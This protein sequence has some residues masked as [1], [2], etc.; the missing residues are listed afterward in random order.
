[1]ERP[2]KKHKDNHQIVLITSDEES[3]YINRDLLMKSSPVLKK[4][5]N[6]QSKNEIQCP[7][8][9][10]QMQKVISIWTKIEEECG[11]CLKDCGAGILPILDYYG[12][13]RAI[14]WRKN[15]IEKEPKMPCIIEWEKTIQE[16]PN[17][18]SKTIH[19]ILESCLSSRGNYTIKDLQHLSQ[20]TLLNIIQLMTT[21]PFQYTKKE[22]YIFKDRDQP[23]DL[24]G[25]C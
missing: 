22:S 2:P 8:A 21:Y 25:G 15:L 6:Y 3:L 12:C 1:M 4:T 17:W 7:F 16:E 5:I 11:D 19:Y 9:S 13:S 20:T 24:F 23:I 10:D 18:T 14:K